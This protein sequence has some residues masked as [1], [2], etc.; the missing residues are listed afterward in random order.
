MPVMPL[1]EQTPAAAIAKPRPESELALTA[2]TLPNACGLSGCRKAVVWFAFA[3]LK[4]RLT[5]A[6]AL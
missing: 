6:A 2:K 5:G 4:L 3:M 1:Y